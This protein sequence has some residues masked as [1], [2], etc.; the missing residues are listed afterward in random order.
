[1]LAVCAA[2]TTVSPAIAA[3]VDA[4]D[5][6]LEELLQVPVVGASK[7]QQKQSEVAAAISVITRDEIR[8]FG[9]RTLA[10]ALASLP[11]VY[12]T[13]DRQYSY[14]G[15]RG[16]SLPGDYNTRALITINGNRAN[17]S[18]YDSGSNGNDFP[19]D[20]DLIERIEFIPGPGGAVYGQNAMF[21]V[22]NVV[23]RSGA[24]VN[25]TTVAAR[26]GNPQGSGEGRV[27][28]GTAFD[29][30]I[31]LLVSATGMH[32]NGQNL[33]FD[34]G[35]SGISGVATGLDGERNRQ[36]L[37]RISAGPWSADLVRGDHRKFDPT[38]AF[39]SDPLVPGQ[40]QAD[41]HD[42]AQ[43]QYQQQ[44]A[45]NKLELLARVFAGG[46]HYTSILSYGTP[47]DFLSVGEWRGAELRLLST[48]WAAHK[49]MLGFEY[50]DN[51][52][53]DQLVYD[54]T[55]PANDLAIQKSGSRS[56]LY[57][58]D[59]WNLGK[60]LKAT[61]GLRADRDD[62]TGNKASPRAALLWQVNGS[63][64]IKALYGR[65]H[66]SPNAYER[67]YDDG[68]AQVANPSLKRETV[69][70][71]EVVADRRI[72]SSLSLRGAAYQWTMQSIITLGTDTVSGLPQYQS[73]ENVRARGLELSEDKTWTTGMRLRGSVSIE[74]VAYESG[75][76]LLNSPRVLGRLNLSA[77]LPLAGLRLGYELRYDSQRLTVNGSEAGGNAVS[78]LNLSARL[79]AQGFEVS[80][81]IFNLF[82]KRYAQPGADNNW[83][84]A[85][86]RDG[87]S[88]RLGLAQSF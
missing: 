23:T 80:L 33:Y 79:R 53:Q 43:L 73:G 22:V 62:A 15:I 1:L 28:W 5:M 12:T 78:N 11:G 14:L 29:N 40:F 21:A 24:D 20:L 57:L 70:T 4:I 39:L 55:A 74:H 45:D 18:V 2:L 87:R 46:E 6:S 3:S 58:Q 7:Y 16:F 67:D 38:G 64:T 9:W 27:T 51:R 36:F 30:G 69:D 19:L 75:A 60:S 72:G 68:F 41:R 56:G 42:L 54:L 65:A 10:D 32:A 59:E 17:D 82:D 86:E 66:R 77:P 63:T 37:F 85:I 31:N 25:G 88:W 8:T 81:G 35:T 61:L 47:Y 44:F 49:L 48:A 13:Y 76:R 71:L 34:Y 84:N 52:R 26:Y 83:Q 50:Q